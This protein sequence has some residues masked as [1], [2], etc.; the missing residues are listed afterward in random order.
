MSVYI[1]EINVYGAND[2]DFV[3]IAAPTGT[4]V[5][6]YTIYAYNQDGTIKSGPYELGSPVGTQG[7]QDIYIIDAGTDGLSLSVDTTVALVDPDG[8]VL[9][10][11]SDERFTTTGTEGPASGVSS[12]SIGGRHETNQ[13]RETQDGGTTY[14]SNASNS[15]G[16]LACFA[17]GTTILTASGELAVETLSPGDLIQTL[18]K[19]PMPVLWA[20]SASI[21]L[22]T[23]QVQQDAIL[24]SANS[25]GPGRPTTDLVVSAQHRILVG[26]A[27]QLDETFDSPAFVPA[28]ALIGLAGIRVMRGKRRVTWH[29][30]ALA[31]HHVVFAEGCA[32]E[33]LLLGPIVVAGLDSNSLAQIDRAFPNRPSGQPINGPLCRPGLSVGQAARAIRDATGR[34]CRSRRP[35][36]AC[37]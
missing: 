27:G 3:E 33:S 15:K 6:G 21:A 13:S 22:D 36:G 8:N 23:A 20:H 18:D 2:G 19:G 9:Q 5:T 24:V 35:I 30:F 26:E 4:D 28:K 37:D 11:L 7:G 34:H 32:S 17:A 16:T 1:S 29:H 25:L 31:D 10:F 14:T 12:D